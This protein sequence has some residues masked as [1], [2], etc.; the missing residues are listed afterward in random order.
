MNKEILDLFK[1]META[2]NISREE[3]IPVICGAIEEGARRGV[4]AGQEVKVTIS[5]STGDISMKAMKT[6]VA[7]VSDPLVEIDLDHARLHVENPQ[8]GSLVEISVDPSTIGRISASFVRQ[9]LR[10]F[11]KTVES[12]RLIDAYQDQVGQLIS[13]KVIG[14]ERGTTTV[15]IGDNT[16]AKLP[17][18][19][20]IRSERLEKGSRH[21]F[22]LKRV[23]AVDESK[24]GSGD[25][26]L[27]PHVI[28]SRADEDFV[29]ALIGREVTELIDGTISIINVARRPGTRT[30]VL[31]AAD[32]P[33]IDPVGCCVG[34]RGA[35]VK[36]LSLELG[37][38]KVDFIKWSEN[39]DEL[40]HE[41]FKTKIYNVQVNEAK[42]TIFF[43]VDKADAG[44]VIGPR[45]D[46]LNLT[47]ELLGYHLKVNVFDGGNTGISEADK[48][49]A[50]AAELMSVGLPQDLVI[51][52]MSVGCTSLEALREPETRNYL[53]SL[54]DDSDVHLFATEEIDGAI[55]AANR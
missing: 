4:N 19:E 6:V 30:K 26:S 9:R 18:K 44:R 22:L 46:N 25:K 12:R 34:V 41:C 43:E 39:L 48:A 15:D 11:L 55:E 38:E 8:I 16:E 3:L 45:G 5:P 21:M 14:V 49:N 47:Q 1:T 29:V 54:K 20:Q 35:R 31:V 2:K 40:L 17:S 13:G 37:K 53:L 32:D 33:K 28:L 23:G 24:S 7:A 36:A 42:N 52:L 50:A 51:R 27:H 10:E